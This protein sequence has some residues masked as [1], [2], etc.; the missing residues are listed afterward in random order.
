[1]KLGAEIAAKMPA[2]SI[3]TINSSKVN[4]FSL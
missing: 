4:P 2:K 3:T 1:M